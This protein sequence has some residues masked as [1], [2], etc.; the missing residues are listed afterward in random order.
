VGVGPGSAAAA[1]SAVRQVEVR[2][3]HDGY[4]ADL[5]FWVPAPRELAFGVLADVEHMPDWVPNLRESR[6]LER[7]ADRITVEHQGVAHYGVLTVPFTTLRQIAFSAPDW[8]RTTQI[9]GTMK[10]H[11]SRMDFVTE[12]AGTRIDYHVQMEPNALAALVMNERRVA[13]ELTEHC[14]AIV[15]EILRRKAATRPAPRE[16]RRDDPGAWTSFDPD[17]SCAPAM[18]EADERNCRGPNDHATLR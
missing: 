3:T 2:R 5:V 12:G 6:V 18:T 17:R 11:E 10:R 16:S 13:S 7:D 4:V 1:E 8:I 15:A 14:N 9:K